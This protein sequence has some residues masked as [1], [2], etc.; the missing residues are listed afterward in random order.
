[1]LAPRTGEASE[2]ARQGGPRARRGEDGL[3]ELS[4]APADSQRTDAWPATGSRR[5]PSAGRPVL[6][7]TKSS[8]GAAAATQRAAGR[9]LALAD[10]AHLRGLLEEELYGRSQQLQ[11]DLRGLLGEGLQ[12]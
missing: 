9:F 7:G 1:V 4:K 12:E 2:E 3:M 5:A 8:G 10:S 6:L 11:L